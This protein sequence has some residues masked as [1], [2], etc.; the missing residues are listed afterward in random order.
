MKAGNEDI[1]R[2]YLLSVPLSLFGVF[3]VAASLNVCLLWIELSCLAVKGL[4]SQKN[5][6]RTRKFIILSCAAYLSIALVIFLVVPVQNYK[7]LAI[8]NIVAML[9][10]TCLFVKGSRMLSKQLSVKNQHQTPPKKENRKKGENYTPKSDQISHEI[11]LQTHPLPV[12]ELAQGTSVTIQRI[13]LKRQKIP[14]AAIKIVVCSRIVSANSFLFCVAG[15]GYVVLASHEKLGV[16]A[17][18]CSLFVMLN[19]L[20]LHTS[21]LTYLSE[22]GGFKKPFMIHLA[23]LTT[24]SKNSAR[25]S[26]FG[27]G[28][29]IDTTVFCCC[30]ARKKVD[31]S[32]EGPVGIERE[33]QEKMES[34]DV[35]EESWDVSPPELSDKN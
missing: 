25:R 30:C 2:G 23:L 27:H 28:L 33:Q 1:E 21:I 22:P 34:N 14:R 7:A 26:S 32:K 31:Y 13:K 8:F 24:N 35:E 12:H 20:I 17:Y 3:T 16:A 5:V 6:V 9:A 15:T 19:P 29:K 18:L 4:A 11:G 10:I